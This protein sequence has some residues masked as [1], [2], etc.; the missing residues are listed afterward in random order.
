MQCQKCKREIPDDAALCC[1]C[2]RRIQKA[3]GHK[4]HRPNGAG[5]VY[6]LTDKHRTKPWAMA[7]G[8]KVLG[9]Y[10]TKAAAMEALEKLSG[11]P[12]GDAIDLTLADIHTLWMAQHYP[13]IKDDAKLAYDSAWAKLEPLAGRK[14]RTLRTEDVQKIVDADVEKGLSRSTTQKIRTLYS[15]L[16]Q[17]AMKKDIIDRNYAQFLILPKQKAII[18]DVFTDEDIRRLKDDAADGNETSMV[19]L[20]LIY[21]GYRLNE[22]LLKPLDQVDLEMGVLF[23]GEKTD[24]GRNRIVTI[25]PAIRPYVEYFASRA[26]GSLFLSGYSGNLLRNNFARRD[27]AETLERLQ[28]S[29]PDRKLHPHCTRYTFAT[30]AKSAGVD[31]DAL[32]RVMGHTDF[33]LTSDV[34]IQNDIDRIRAEM[35]KIR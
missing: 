3:A 8:G 14:M 33:R 28:I 19:I 4:R 9:L 13:R 34:Y 31:D 23:G 30:R 15:Q 27:F 2:G 10:A 21:T 16:C 18:R 17:Y 25:N 11:K 24:A 12:I 26:T 7:K 22:L 20:I 1:Y 6:K 29:G 32:K 5:S 35:D